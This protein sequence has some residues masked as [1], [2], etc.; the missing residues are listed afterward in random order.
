MLEDDVQVVMEAVVSSLPHFASILYACLLHAG[1]L[2]SEY[3]V[4]FSSFVP[5]NHHQSKFPL[6]TAIIE[7]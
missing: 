6:R 5:R 2:R 1:R 3:D 4:G 7:T